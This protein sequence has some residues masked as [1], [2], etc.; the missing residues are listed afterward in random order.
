MAITPGASRRCS[1]CDSGAKGL[2]SHHYFLCWTLGPLGRCKPVPV[3]YGRIKYSETRTRGPERHLALRKQGLPACLPPHLCSATD[4]I[5]TT[6][7]L[8]SR[9]RLPRDPHRPR[10]KLRLPVLRRDFASPPPSPLTSLAF[11][12]NR[13]SGWT[14]APHAPVAGGRG[15]RTGQKRAR[16][17]KGRWK[18]EAPPH[19]EGLPCSSPSPVLMLL[20]R[21]LP[22]TCTAGHTC[23]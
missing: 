19:P 13:T 15:Q 4:P 14:R 11:Q 17:G 9:P 21:P 16:S 1:V 12:P 2:G 7:S 22:F 5:S 10:G 23:V 6:R 18:R 8:S 20:P 3:S